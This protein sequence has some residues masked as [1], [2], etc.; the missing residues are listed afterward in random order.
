MALVL[1]LVL[2][3]SL[4]ASYENLVDINGRLIASQRLPN[5]HSA[6]LKFGFNTAV[7]AAEESVSEVNDATGANNGPARCILDTS[8]IPLVLVSSD[9][10]ND[11]GLEITIEGVDSNW[12]A[13]SA[14]VNLGVAALTSGTVYSIVGVGTWLRV[15]RAY[16][17]DSTAVQGT[18]YI[19]KDNITD[20]GTDGVPDVPSTQTLAVINAAEQQTLHACYTIPDDY[21]AGFFL[22]EVCSSVN[23]SGGAQASTFRLRLTTEAGADR[24]QLR[25]GVGAGLTSCQ[26]FD[27]P[28]KYAPRNALELTA[29]G[30]TNVDASGTFAGYLLR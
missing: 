10:A 3:V 20:D 9:D 18:V 25:F 13:I 11:A 27:P 14:T 26:R 21:A 2:A 4:G 7:N 23:A 5:G 8:A 28:K 19:H 6:L 29:I 17:S 30:G 12:D 15:N 22:T 24:T 16:V 1:G